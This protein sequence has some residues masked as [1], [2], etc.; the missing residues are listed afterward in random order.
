G[1]HIPGDFSTWADVVIV[2]PAVPPDN[3]FVQLARDAGK[4]VT[5]QMEIFFNLFG[6]QIVGITGAN[7]KSTTAALTAHL[8]AVSDRKVFL[9]GNIGNRP[10]LTLLDQ[11]GD[12]D[13]A[14]LEISSFQAEQLEGCPRGCD[15]S[16]ITN[17]TANHLDRHGTF[18]Q[19]C[20]AKEIL[21]A[22]QNPSCLSIF[23]AE[24]EV[25]RSWHEKYKS[26]TGRECVLYSADDVDASLAERFPLCGG[27]NLSNLAAGLAVARHYGTSEDRIAEAVGSFQGLANR[28]ELVAE[29]G[30]VRWYDDS[31][32]TTP[33]SAI[34]ALEA[35]DEGKVI[36]AG[37]YDKGLPF[38]EF[39]KAIA[40]RAKGAVLI[41]KTA[42]KIA[43][44]IELAGGGVEVIGA[45]SMG[46]AVEKAFSLCAGGDVVLMSPACASYDMFVNYKQRGEVFRQEVSLLRAKVE[47]S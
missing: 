18:A 20:R 44:A 9:G 16:V 36:I 22:G 31:I 35:F 38:D 3:E 43:T 21:F 27:M 4:V 5:S 25:C 2:N 19:Y 41:G 46:Q 14:V 12:D 8:L 10:L 29:F 11:M 33:A 15:V 28:L 30:G 13:I 47:S 32:A 26:E 37:G 7:G 45:E 40:S 1:G 34:A 39:G 23:C 17:L 6:G 42:D 24:D